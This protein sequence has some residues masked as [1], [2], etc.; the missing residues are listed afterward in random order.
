MTNN[1]YMTCALLKIIYMHYYLEHNKSLK[2][3]RVPY[4]WLTLYL[5]DKSKKLL[6][7]PKPN[8]FISIDVNCKKFVV[9]IMKVS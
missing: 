7:K 1:D 2:H 4:N 9:K 8:C 6:F 3:K 5:M